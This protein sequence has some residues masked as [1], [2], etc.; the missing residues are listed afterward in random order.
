MVI[1]GIDPG[2]AIVG[3]GVVD[4]ENN[5][6]TPLEFRS[7]T[8][9]AG[10]P[11]ER[12]LE[13]IYDSLTAVFLQYKP[14]AVAVE[15]LF[16]QHNQT[17]VISVAMARGVI[18]LSAQKCGIPFYEYTPMK[19]KQSVAGYGG[20][21]KQQVME[22]TRRLLGLREVP[23]PDDT[24]DALAVAICHAHSSNSALSRIEAV[25]K[26]GKYNTGGD[27]STAYT[28]SGLKIRSSWG[29]NG[30][31]VAVKKQGRKSSK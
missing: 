12:R 4:Y 9:P 16:Y 21:D 15:Q 22:M 2:Y 7:I 10:M 5:K 31:G 13:I 19:I 1:M 14:E 25:S 18:L 17:T 11:L 27:R 20:A 8:T 30:Y 28:E 29:G 23:R 26:L 3:Y 6:F 24:A